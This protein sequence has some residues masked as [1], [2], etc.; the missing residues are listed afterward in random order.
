MALAE[1]VQRIP[2]PFVIR[3]WQRLRQSPA[4]DALMRL[5]F[6]LWAFL[7]AMVT[8]FDLL[9][10]LHKS[11]AL[12]TGVFAVN[13]AMRLS[14]FCFMVLLAASVLA[15]TRPAAKAPGLAPR[16]SALFGTFL[17]YAFA[18]FP[19]RELSPAAEIV[20][21][22][23]V[24]VG[25]ASAAYVLGQLGR[26]FSIMAEAR[27]LVTSGVY[28]Y[29]RHPLYLAEELAAIGV[30][31][32]FLSYWTVA[33]LCLQI[34]FQLRRMRNEETVLAAAFPTYAAYRERTARLIPGVY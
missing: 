31:V 21:T 9:Q 22:M 32:Q 1:R 11:N 34:A 6:L 19:R 8:A 2:L 30:A 4:Y 29:V 25:T 5:P 7:V 24:L 23:L 16:L 10:Y 26:S 15:R 13:V 17:I 18:L 12:A 27:Q 28:R 20:S 33:I 3:D 14:T